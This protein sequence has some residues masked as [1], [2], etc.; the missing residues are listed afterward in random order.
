MEVFNLNIK[1]A[2]LT[3]F[4][5]AV[6]LMRSLYFLFFT[7]LLLLDSTRSASPHINQHHNN[8]MKKASACC[9]LNYI[10]W[11]IAVFAG[12]PNGLCGCGCCAACS[13]SQYSLEM[14]NL[15]VVPCTAIVFHPL[16]VLNCSALTGVAG[17]L[18][19]ATH[20]LVMYFI[21]H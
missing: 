1:R 14:S 8:V 21:T 4:S 18:G 10:C 7:A 12:L 17:Y 3:C 6:F 11:L 5:A 20:W 2:F 19:I 16:C 9:P 13:L 15:R